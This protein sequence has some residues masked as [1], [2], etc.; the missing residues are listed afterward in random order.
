MPSW[1]DSSQ[2]ADRR[3]CPG[4]RS[5]ERSELALDGD[6][7]LWHA[8]HSIIAITQPASFPINQL[9]SQHRGVHSPPLSASSHKKHQLFAQQ[10][11]GP[12]SFLRKQRGCSNTSNDLLVSV[13]F[14]S[15]VS[16]HSRCGVLRMKR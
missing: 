8:A 6:V 13:A 15:R 5:D 7:G 3:R 16:I 10:D 11:R 4:S 14:T 12:L 9:A 2:A 1:P